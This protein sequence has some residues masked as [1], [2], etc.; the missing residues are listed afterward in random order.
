MSK[1][2]PLQKPCVPAEK[3]ALRRALGLLRESNAQISGDRELVD[4]S[5]GPTACRLASAHAMQLQQRFRKPETQRCT[6]VIA[7]ATLGPRLDQP[8]ASQRSREGWCYLQDAHCTDEKTKGQ[9][10]KQLAQVT[11]RGHQGQGTSMESF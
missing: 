10:E 6:M 3:P 1:V 4:I 9:R 7:I 11:M 5:Q 8:V 2:Q